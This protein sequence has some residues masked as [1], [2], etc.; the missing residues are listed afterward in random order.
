MLFNSRSAC[1]VSCFVFLL[2][3]T[4]AYGADVAS[5]DVR[6]PSG[7]TP[8][9]YELS[10]HPD[11]EKLQFSGNVTITIDVAQPAAEVVLNAAGLSFDSVS[12]DQDATARV[13]LDEKRER[14]ILHFAAP[15]TPG[16]HVLAITYHGP[17]LRGTLGF[18]AMDYGPPAGRRRMLATNFEPASERG[19]MPSWDEPGFKAT[20]SITVDAPADRMAVSNMPIETEAPLPNRMKRVRFA[21]TPKM[22]TYLL[23][24][25]IGDYQRITAEADGVQV[26]V[27]VARG[28][29]ARG[30]YALKEAVRL[31]HYYNDYFGVH[32]PLPKLDLIAAPGEI[33]G[34]SMENW[35]AI[36]YSQK[37]VLFDSRTSTEADRHEVFLV[38][39]HEM[40]HQWFGDLVTMQWWDNLW[41]NEGFARWMQTKAA[42]DLNPE[43]RTG[44]GAAAIVEG[45]MRA[46]ARAST[47]PVEQ[48]VATVEEAELAFDSITYDK[49]ATVI[50][51]LESHVTPERFRTG[52][53]SYM[54]AHAFGNARS[55]DLWGELQAAAGRP[56]DGIAADFT[57][58]AGL[59][60]VTVDTDVQSAAP[61]QVTLSQSRFF[62]AHQ[63]GE[64][65]TPPTFWRLPLVNEAGPATSEV[66]LVAAQTSV[67]AKGSPLVNTGHK[68]YTRVRYAPAL[69]GTLAARF[70]A[71]RPEDQ[72]GMLDDAWALGQSQYAPITNL[73]ELLAALPAD[74][75]PTVWARALPILQSIDALYD[76]GAARDAYR[77]WVRMRLAPV[78][79]LIGW[80]APAHEPVPAATL[81]PA[82]FEA[83]GRY[84]D[85]QVLA[86][87]RKRD[88]ADARPGAQRSTNR[89]ANRFAHAIVVRHADAAVFATLIKKLRATHDPL[90]KLNQL[91]AL[92]QVADP[93]LAE[94][95][96][97]LAIGPD[98]PAGSTPNLL[99]DIAREHPDLTWQFAV[100]HVD[101]P[102]FPL[103]RASRMEV[104]PSLPAA[105]TNPARGAELRRY[106]AAHLPPEAEREV[107]SAV[108][109]ITLNAQVR[110]RELPRIDRWL[111]QAP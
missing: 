97:L 107:Q 51:M 34:G 1:L 23:F 79:T 17:I 47:H 37:H 106:A 91:E 16:R 38:V 83:L 11:A 35:G 31:M 20:F 30:R 27:V 77:A 53:R 19:L 8:T 43:W 63:E 26:G 57:R 45:G 10:L 108:A 72:I 49:G 70:A 7:I 42:D 24:L 29:T 28:E 87:A 4:A 71:L 89:A 58:R 25:G 32:Y 100:D 80:D 74:A 78:A 62:E 61:G 92:T 69:F 95:L 105:S 99:S 6:L 101:A 5:S 104:I 67:M 50:G 22:S 64:E 82:L 59:P 52:V 18:F 81:R 14:A 96:L 75:E 60:L 15:L 9:H 94:Q 41:L 73:F 90:D 110:E 39:S 12:A 65:E 98:V 102:D 109:R 33:Q 40:A 36:F 48:P 3:E 21:T 76:A 44:L 13:T 85:P 93:K 103:D 56:V 68:A 46:D 84:D 2:L 111:A 66:L 86:E 88:A 55:A 54:K